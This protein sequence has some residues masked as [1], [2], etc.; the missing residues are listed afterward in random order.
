M[1]NN[2][3][4][5]IKLKRIENKISQENLC[6]GICTPSYLSRIENNRLIPNTEIY[7]L[8]CERLGLE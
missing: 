2:I 1:Q 7:K 6:R 3:G 5:I 4:T 8:L